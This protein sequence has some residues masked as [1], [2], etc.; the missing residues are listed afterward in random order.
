MAAAAPRRGVAQL[1]E[2]RF[3]WIEISG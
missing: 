1:G 2:R 3:Q